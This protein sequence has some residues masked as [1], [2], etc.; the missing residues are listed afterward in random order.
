MQF[1]GETLLPAPPAEV[2]RA[3]LQPDRLARLVDPQGRHRLLPLGPGLWDGEVTV[4][5][6][7]FGQRHPVRVRL[8]EAGETLLL[9]VCGL[10]RSE[11]LSLTARC[12]LGPAPG[13]GTRVRYAVHAELSRLGAMLG[14][15]ALRRSVEDFFATLA[16]AVAGSP[17]GS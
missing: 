3:L 11:G 9:E 1:D 13:G 7:P 6:P 8:A 5:P 17:Q 15:G 4:G 16:G 12:S 14:A 10:G 2:R